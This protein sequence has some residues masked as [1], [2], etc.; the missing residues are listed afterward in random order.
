MTRQILI[1]EDEPEIAALIAMHLEEAGYKVHCEDNGET[2]LA[3]A[4]KGHFDLIMLD[5]MLPRMDGLEVCRKIRG[6]LAAQPIVMLTAKTDEI[7]KVLGL[8]L[9]ADDYITKPFGVRELLAR[10]KAVLRRSEN[11]REGQSDSIQEE[12]RMGHLRV[13]FHRRKVLLGDRSL[14]LTVKE[15]DLLKLFSSH[16]GV[17]FSRQQL[18]DKVW[19]YSFSGYEHTV[20]SHI[21]RLRAKIEDDPAHPRYILTVWGVGYRFAEA[22]ELTQ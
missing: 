16:P 13:D 9:G 6:K 18:L 10:V 20:N 5:V 15:F 2:G 8:E 21:N 22:A 12:I 1:I 11:W 19:G 3:E 14:E 4:L 17:P 7:D